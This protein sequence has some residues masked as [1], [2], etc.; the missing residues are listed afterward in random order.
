MLSECYE[1]M[2]E[3]EIASELSDVLSDVLGEEWQRYLPVLIR[4]HELENS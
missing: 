3:V 4:V 1:I 2:E